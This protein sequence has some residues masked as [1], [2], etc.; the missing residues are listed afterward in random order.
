[1]LEVGRLLIA[2]SEAGVVDKLKNLVK[3]VADDGF[4]HVVIPSYLIGYRV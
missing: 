3:D 2:V 1:M 4:R